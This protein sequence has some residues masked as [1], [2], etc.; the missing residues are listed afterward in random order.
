MTDIEM[1]IEQV[2]SYKK[3]DENAHNMSP[4]DTVAYYATDKCLKYWDMAIKA[5]E[6]EQC[7]ADAIAEIEQ[8]VKEEKPE[9]SSW[10]C[11]LKYSIGIIRKHT[12]VGE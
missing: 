4:K 9:D 10:A 2:K 1:A 8:I 7:I 3:I 6:R 12:G 5:L 11:G